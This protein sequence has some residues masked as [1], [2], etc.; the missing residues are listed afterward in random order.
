VSRASLSLASSDSSTLQ[1]GA[2][3]AALTIALACATGCAT[4]ANYD[5]PAGPIV[6]GP[7]IP[8]AR[9]APDDLRVVTFNLK[10]SEHIDRA[11]DLLSRPGP[12]SG[13]DLLIMQ[14]MDP[15]STEMLA[16]TLGL[17]YVYVPSTVHHST[18]KDFGVAILSPWTL[19]DTRKIL[20]PHLHRFRKMRRSALVATVHTQAGPVRVYAVHF[21]SQFGAWD[22]VRRDQ[23]RAIAE[24]AADTADPVVVAGDFNGTAGARELKAA[25]FTWLTEQVHNTLGPFDLDHILVRG[26]CPAGSPAATKAPD[27]THASDHSP[28]WTV[29]RPCMA[30]TPSGDRAP[31]VSR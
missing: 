25:G 13:A 20:L 1:A 15:A 8:A 30:A 12:L 27:L 14:E 2:R 9:P 19:E 10:L 22:S 7:M 29:V 23:A 17:N 18:R 3:V 21:E 4:I 6:R 24:D 11:A 26:L 16:R 31:R 28:V 5:D